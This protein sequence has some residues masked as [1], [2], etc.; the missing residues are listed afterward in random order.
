MNECEKTLKR[1]SSPSDDVSKRG[2]CGR[3]GKE[4]MG[5]RESGVLYRGREKE[6]GRLPMC[7]TS[8]F[9]LPPSS[10]PLSVHEGTT[11]SNP[12]FVTAPTGTKMSK[13]KVQQ[14]GEKRDSECSH[15]AVSTNDR[16]EGVGDGSVD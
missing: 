6:G 13:E 16:R 11:N 8:A 15:S 2:V 3:G 7:D 1:S 10:S 9:S 4:W 12:S 5:E 14:E